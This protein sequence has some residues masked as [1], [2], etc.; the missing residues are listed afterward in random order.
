[1]PSESSF[2]S[3]I[4]N[5]IFTVR[6]CDKNSLIL[7]DEIVSST[8]PD[9][10]L[11]LASAILNYLNKRKSTSIITTHIKGLLEYGSRKSWC[12]NRRRNLK[13]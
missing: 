12:K 11:A 9:E 2:S 5:I 6:N 1:M 10:G 13:I 3:H 7:I 8:D 4:S